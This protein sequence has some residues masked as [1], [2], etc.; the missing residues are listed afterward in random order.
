MSLSTHDIGGARAD[1]Y[2]ERKYFFS[3][4]NVVFRDAAIT[5]II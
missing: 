1:S 5:E 4:L 2:N 3:V